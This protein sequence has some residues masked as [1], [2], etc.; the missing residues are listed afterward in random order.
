MA[1]FVDDLGEKELS[2]F[3]RKP[4]GWKAIRER[5]KKF[6]VLQ[7]DN[8]PYV[9]LEHGNILSKNLNAKMAMKTMRHFS[10]D[11]GVNELPAVLEL[12]GLR[13]LA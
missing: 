1:G 12:L 5:A 10:G 13:A 8:D 6:Y 11:D 3:F 2:N 4:I 9:P 7:S